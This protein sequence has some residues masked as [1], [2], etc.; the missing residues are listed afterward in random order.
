MGC[1]SNSNN[2][3]KET[4]DKP[5]VAPK[6]YYDLDKLEENMKDSD[7]ITLIGSLGDAVS[8]NKKADILSNLK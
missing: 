6:K 1:A 5:K 8:I 4:N 2:T 7:V 3:V